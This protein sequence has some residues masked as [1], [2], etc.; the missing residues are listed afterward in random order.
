MIDSTPELEA[1]RQEFRKF[2]ASEVRPLATEIDAEERVSEDLIKAI[3]AR[4]Y[5]VPWLG[6]EYGG[7]GLGQVAYG[8]LNE[9]INH[10]CSS[11]R[12]LLTVQGMVA[13]AILRAG[14]SAQREAWLPRLAS[15]EAI[16]AFALSEPLVG[17]DA[18][19]PE[20][21]ATHAAGNYELAGTKRWISFAQRADVFLV[22]AALDGSPTA[23]LVERE[24]PG[25][26]VNPMT[27]MIGS[28]GSMLAEI[29][30]AKCEVPEANR[31]GR[32]GMGFSLVASS[33]L[34]L[35]RYSVAWG[36]VG[37]A[38]A[39]LDASASYTG[40]RHQFGV[41]IKEHQLVRRLM[42]DMLTR[43]HTAD[44]LCRKAGDLRE[45]RDPRAGMETMIAKYYASTAAARTAADAVQLHG[46]EGCR[47]DHV[48]A[49][50]FRD[51][52]VMEIIEGSTQLQ[53]AT[54]A[55]YAYR[56]HPVP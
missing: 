38:R 49:R 29:R 14:S 17:S 39:C 12:S 9:E 45:N 25:L 8:L 42:T 48:V 16:A 33:A 43:L 18:A 44:L 7:T 54:I 1:Q 32:E 26:T 51:A 56:D 40:E 2:V 6:E 31:V 52:K 20:A 53:Q 5:L 3:A 13:Q 36:C 23:F 47:D 24:R 30:F 37:L 28:R 21:T 19:H 50:M 10:A 46:A 35:G 4:G 11:V 22:L 27:G 15:G 55:D 41:A 34:E